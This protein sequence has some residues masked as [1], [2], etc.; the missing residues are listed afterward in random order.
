MTRA[1][2]L[3]GEHRSGLAVYEVTIDNRMQGK[4]VVGTTYYAWMAIEEPWTM[5]QLSENIPMD[6]TV[7][8]TFGLLLPL[9]GRG[10]GPP[11]HAM[12]TKSRENP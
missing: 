5:C 1:S 8:I 10:G 4:Q 3:G 9:L 6:S 7:S 12:I 11:K 2:H